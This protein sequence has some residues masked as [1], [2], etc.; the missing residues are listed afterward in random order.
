MMKKVL[1]MLLSLALLC[2][3]LS[4]CTTS[5]GGSDTTAKPDSVTEAPTGSG[6][7]EDEKKELAVEK[8]GDDDFPEEFNIMVRASRY[9]YLFCDDE[10]SPLE[11]DRSVWSRNMQIEELYNIYFDITEVT[12]SATSFTTQLSGGTGAFDLVCFDYWWKLEQNGFFYDVA[13]MQ[14]IDMSDSWWYQGWNDNSTINGVSYTIVGDANLEVLQNIEVLFF[15]KQIASSHELDLYELVD[16]GEWTIEKMMEICDAVSLNLDDDDT[17]NDVYGALYDKHSFRNALFSAGLTLTS[18]AENG[19]IEIVAN[20][21]QNINICDAVT[22]LINR[23]SVNFSDTNTRV[24]D[25]TLFTEERS[26][27]YATGL[28]MG[29]SLKSSG[30]TNYGILITP[31][32]STDSEYHTSNYGAS[33]FGIPLDCADRHMSAMILNALNYLSEDTVVYTYYEQVNK[34]RADAPQD[35]E[36]IDLSRQY[37]TMDFAFIYD[38]GL[39]SAFYTAVKNNTSVSTELASIVTAAETTLAE[40]I[41]GFHQ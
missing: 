5:Q 11:L 35:S 27:F 4:A 20:A 21:A 22:S 3:S 26:L 31:K 9:D 38:I 17:A 12:D 7:T 24:R 8:F 14:E 30:M 34:A 39:T 33:V 15:N 1:A 23:A 25:Y 16:N 19:A 32:Y 36:M 13:S 28:I 10:T 40:L 41:A 18:V 37:M 29:S 6:E 2:I